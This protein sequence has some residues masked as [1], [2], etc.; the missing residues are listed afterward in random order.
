MALQSRVHLAQGEEL[1]LLD[2]AGLRPHG[3]Q[4]RGGMALRTNGTLATH[5][6]GSP[7]PLSASRLP[8]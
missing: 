4:G 6:S 1:A 5:P 8:F 2:E 3:V 7:L